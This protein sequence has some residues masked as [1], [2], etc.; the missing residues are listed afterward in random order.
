MIDPNFKH[1][2]KCVSIADYMEEHIVNIIIDQL[3]ISEEEEENG[4]HE[5][6]VK[7][8]VAIL[9]HRTLKL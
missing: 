9:A 1:I 6:A 8:V 7:Q 4:T 5:I 3:Q 2:N